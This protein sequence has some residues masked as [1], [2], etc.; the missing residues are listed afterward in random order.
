MKFLPVD[1]CTILSNLQGTF[2][3]HQLRRESANI[4]GRFVLGIIDPGGFMW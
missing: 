1:L 3:K 2:I 4:G